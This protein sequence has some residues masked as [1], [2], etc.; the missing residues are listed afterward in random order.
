[1]Q[2]Q[3]SGLVGNREPLASLGGERVHHN[4]VC[5]VGI[6]VEPARE[7]ALEAISQAVRFREK[8]SGL[9]P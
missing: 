2:E 8:G 3:V 1:M 4:H 7:F 9:D 6:P 5:T